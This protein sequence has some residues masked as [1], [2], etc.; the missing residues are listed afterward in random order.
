M[1][2]TA[3]VALAAFGVCAA[4]SAY[5][6][7]RGALPPVGVAVEESDGIWCAEFPAAAAGQAV[8]SGAPVAIV[9]PEVSESLVLQG[10]IERIQPGDCTTAFPQPRWGDYVA[11]RVAFP[12]EGAS[13]SASRKT[14]GLAV[15]TSVRWSRAAN[16]RLRA[17]LDGDGL[18]EEARRCAA[19]EGEHFTLWSARADGS[20]E[21]RVHEYFDWGAIVDA[22]CQPGEDGRDL[23]R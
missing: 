5:S 9:F 19:G 11:F 12:T 17:D 10:Q 4:A 21:R 13:G 2:H 20:F 6:Q 3:F 18:P 8:V 15:T 14:V 23:V 7:T 16:G 1:S 22:T